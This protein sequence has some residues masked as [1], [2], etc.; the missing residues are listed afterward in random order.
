[1]VV[2]PQARL[3][4][5]RYNGVKSMLL[6]TRRWLFNIAAAVSVVVMVIL[7]IP[8]I[9]GLDFKA[10]LGGGGSVLRINPGNGGITLHIRTSIATNW[11]EFHLSIHDQVFYAGVKS[12]PG[13][14]G[15]IYLRVGYPLLEGGT[16][17]NCARKRVPF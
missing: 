12:W 2:A 7:V 3:E 13:S 8:W 16:M 10:Y 17:W 9:A 4:Y 14:H 6:R 5:G 15:H 1:M 11:S